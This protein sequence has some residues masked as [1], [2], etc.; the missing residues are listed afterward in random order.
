MRIALLEDDPDQAALVRL[1]LEDDGHL[2]TT[3]VDGKAF[4]K[5]V[6][7]ES[8]DLFLLDWNTPQMSGDQVLE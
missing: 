7:R 2:V 8:Y 6:A 4:L 5:H 3:L 1:W